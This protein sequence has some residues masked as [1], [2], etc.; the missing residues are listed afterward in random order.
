[1]WNRLIPERPALALSVGLAGL[2]AAGPAAAHP[3]VF[4]DVRQTLVVDGGGAVAAVRLDWTFDE[5][6]STWAIAGL[7]ANG[8]GS[9]EPEELS[10]LA[11][12]NITNLAEY[13]YFTF[14]AHAGAEVAYA[15]VNDARMT[16]ENGLLRLSFTLPFAAPA[17]PA[18]GPVL[19]E[20]F[21]PSFYVA[22]VLREADGVALEGALK[23]DCTLSRTEGLADPTGVYLPDELTSQAGYETFGAQ[24]AEK[25][26]IA[27]QT[28]S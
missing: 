20:T 25:V 2:A 26:T 9:F 5:L 23:P 4:V 1:M 10:G 6:Y 7:D 21:D 22:M 24:F 19:V 12:D 18:R 28:P 13:R 15:P 17:D 11:S 16:L 8:N 3:H 14:A 27:C